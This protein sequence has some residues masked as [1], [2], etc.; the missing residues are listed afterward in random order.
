MRLT[1]KVS[2][3]R[4]PPARLDKFGNI[5]GAV[6]SPRLSCIWKPGSNHAIRISANRAFRAPSLI[7]NYLDQ[8]VLNP[9]DLKPLFPN[10]PSQYASLVEDR[11]LLPQ[12]V[13]GN[14]DLQEESITAYELGYVGSVNGET[15]VGFNIYVNDTHENINFVKFPDNYDPYTEQNPPA[16]W[17]L[18]PSYITDLATRGLYLARTANQFRNLGPIRKPGVELFVERAAA[19]QAAAGGPAL[20]RARDQHPPSQPGE[21]RDLVVRAPPDRQHE[22]EPRRPIVLGR[23]AAAR[24]RRLRRCLHDV[25][26][27]LRRPMGAGP[28]PHH[29][30]RHEPHERRGAPARLR[31]HLEE[32]RL[33]RRALRVLSRGRARARPDRPFRVGSRRKRWARRRRGSSSA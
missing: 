23:R 3:R 30:A 10:L 31:G 22:P 2:Q 15:T 20:S 1:L 32:D 4:L 14:R 18:P 12:R 5:A 6:V 25:Q 13:L 8:V 29:L 28:H 16:G 9:V 21:R 19:S 7:N 33:P 24:L 26:R 11:F 17:P 27:Q